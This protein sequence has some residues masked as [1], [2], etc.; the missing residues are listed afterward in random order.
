MTPGNDQRRRTARR[1]C[2]GLAACAAALA[3]VA[4]LPLGSDAHASNQRGA[5]GEQDGPF[6]VENAQSMDAM[7][8]VDRR[9]RAR[10][11]PGDPF[12][13]VGLGQGDNDFREGLHAAGRG[14]YRPAQV[15][16]R[17]LRSRQLAM[18]EAGAT[19]STRVARGTPRRFAAPAPEGYVPPP[20][21]E[22]ERRSTAWIGMLLAAASSLAYFLMRGRVDA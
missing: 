1:R 16:E 2:A 5:M 13:I 4:A 3:A 6:F 17:D 21:P 15:D 11:H 12:E 18:Y 19:F 10:M 22:E 9:D 14:A 20:P 7:D 8:L